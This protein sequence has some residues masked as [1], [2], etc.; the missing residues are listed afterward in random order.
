VL[1]ALTGLDLRLCPRCGKGPVLR[2]PLGTVPPEPPRP[3]DT[4]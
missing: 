2:F 4:S 1:L 3:P